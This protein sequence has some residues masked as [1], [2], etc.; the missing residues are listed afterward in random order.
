MT[1][2]VFETTIEDE[3]ISD[4]DYEQEEYD[5]DADRGYALGIEHR[6]KA[7][8]IVAGLNDAEED[9]FWDAYYS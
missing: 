9:G 5:A 3:V 1:D 7:Y 6:R 8:E 2:N 4:E